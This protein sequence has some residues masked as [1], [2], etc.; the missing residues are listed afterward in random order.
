MNINE[1]HN[2]L[3]DL[4]AQVKKN[5][6]KLNALDTVVEKAI[7]EVSEAVTP[8]DNDSVTQEE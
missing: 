1:L 5:T 2:E 3:I 6:D 8:T 4:K 7:D